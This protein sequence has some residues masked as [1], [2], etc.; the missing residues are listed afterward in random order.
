MVRSA[1]CGQ[2]SRVRV[3]RR[4]RS[5]CLVDSGGV[6]TASMV[7][8]PMPGVSAPARVEN[9]RQTVYACVEPRSDSPARWATAVLLAR[10][11]RASGE[12]RDVLRAQIVLAAPVRG[13]SRRPSRP[14]WQNRRR[15]LRMV[16]SV[17][18]LENDYVLS[19]DEK[20]SVQARSRRHPSRPPGP[21]RH[22]MQVESEYRRRGTLAYLAA[23][24][25]HRGRVIGHCAP[26]IGIERFT[27]LVDKVMTRQ[28][29]H[30]S[31]AGVLD[32]G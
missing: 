14:C 1:S 28:P 8:G 25:V 5:E 29:V 9:G 13:R 20:P 23:Y 31:A 27:A 3:I 30:L 24:D 26:S 18:A 6:G 17:D 2:R 4:W 11:R 15:H 7:L 32:R 16:S 10:A 12:H 22:P 21:G 19:A